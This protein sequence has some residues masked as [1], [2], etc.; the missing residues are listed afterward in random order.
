MDEAVAQYEAILNREP[1]NL[2]ARLRTSR[3]LSLAV[4]PL[5]SIAILEAGPAA[6]PDDVEM[7]NEPDC[8]V[9]AAVTD[10]RIVARRYESYKRL[11]RQMREL[12]EKQK[13]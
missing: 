5:D 7:A 2:A 12:A 11:V 8:A 6:L 4:R 9:T 13:P 3:A 1:R 10:G